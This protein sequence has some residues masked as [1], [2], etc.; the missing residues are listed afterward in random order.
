M[1]WAVRC[2]NARV[3]I[4]APNGFY[5]SDADAEGNYRFENMDLK[6]YTLSSPAPNVAKTDTSDWSARLLAATKIRSWP[7]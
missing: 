4:P 3:A 2:P 1:S 7:P 6:D 5:W